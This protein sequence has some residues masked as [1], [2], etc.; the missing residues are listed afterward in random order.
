MAAFLA[1]ALL[2]PS[3]RPAEMQGPV[4]ESVTANQEAYLKK[5]FWQI[6]VPLHQIIQEAEA[7]KEYREILLARLSNMN[8]SFSEKGAQMA[9]LYESGSPEQLYFITQFNLEKKE[10]Q[11][12]A[13]KS[14]DR[15]SP[16]F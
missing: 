5:A 14:I 7:G 1:L 4:A 11:A 9:C 3:R 12:L 15:N 6:N 13:L 16:S 8:R 2:L 10:N